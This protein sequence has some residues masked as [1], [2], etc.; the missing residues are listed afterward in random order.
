MIYNWPSEFYA[1]KNVVSD[2][3]MLR[4]HFKHNKYRIGRYLWSIWK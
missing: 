2:F 1:G 3:D 4:L